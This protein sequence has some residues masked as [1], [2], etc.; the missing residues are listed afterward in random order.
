MLGLVATLAVAGCGGGGIPS[1]SGSGGDQQALTTFVSLP[2]QG[3]TSAYFCNFFLDLFAIEGNQIVVYKRAGDA[4]SKGETIGTVASGSDLGEMNGPTSMTC[5][6]LGNLAV[7]DPG[8][9]RIDIFSPGGASF[10]PKT[11]FGVAGTGSGQFQKV[12]AVAADSSNNFYAVDETNKVVEEWTT[13]NGAYA[14]SKNFGS[15]TLSSPVSIA[16]D[17][18]NNLWVSDAG[19]KNIVGISNLLGLVVT[20]INPPTALATT[21]VPGSIGL[22]SAGDVFVVDTGNSQVEEFTNSSGTYTYKGVVGS[23]GPGNNQYANPSSISL[24]AFNDVYVG[25]IGNSRVAAFA[26]Q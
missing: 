4:F 17:S 20:T 3:L 23:I 21:F 18:S 7:A 5:D 9:N 15:G 24:D 1:G 16:I 8:N 19:N 12:V 25:D 6:L 13:N 11:S 14:F 26:P 10:L 2:T 22:D